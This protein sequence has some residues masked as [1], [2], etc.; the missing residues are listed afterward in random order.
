MKN[1][2]GTYWISLAGQPAIGRVPPSLQIMN[3]VHPSPQQLNQIARHYGVLVEAMHT[4]VAPYMRR[5]RIL[6]DGTF[7][8]MV[9]SYGVDTLQVWPA[10]ASAGTKPFVAYPAYVDLGFA[11]IF[12]R[13]V[14]DLGSFTKPPY[15][16]EPEFEVPRPERAYTAQPAVAFSV[17]YGPLTTLYDEFGYEIVVFRN[18]TYKSCVVSRGDSPPFASPMFTLAGSE[19][20]VQVDNAYFT[21]ATNLP[22]HAPTPSQIETGVE[23]WSASQVGSRLDPRGATQGEPLPSNTWVVIENA[24]LP[25]GVTSGYRV[26]FVPQGASGTAVTLSTELFDAYVAADAAASAIDAANEA[27]YQAAYAQWL[28]DWQQ[29]Y[30]SVYKGWLDDCKA[31]DDMYPSLGPYPGMA[32]QRA[33]ARELQL[34]ALRNWLDGGVQGQPH[35]AARYLEFPWNIA[36]RPKNPL[37]TTGSV[38]VGT[39]RA[40]GLTDRLVEYTVT[41]ADRL[42]TVPRPAAGSPLDAVLF[43]GD[44]PHPLLRD[45]AMPSCLYGWV[46]NGTYQRYAAYAQPPYEPPAVRG[47][48]QLAF[49][50]RPGYDQFLRDGVVRAETAGS[51]ISSDGYVPPGTRITLVHLEYE[52]FDVFSGQWIW[53]PCFDIRLYDSV[54][55]VSLGQY[56]MPPPPTPPANGDWPRKVRV[57][58]VQTL[59]RLADMRWSAPVTVPAAKLK[60]AGVWEKEVAAGTGN[61][62][63]CIVI[64]ERLALSAYPIKGGALGVPQWSGYLADTKA[65]L[66]NAWD[67]ALNTPVLVSHALAIAKKV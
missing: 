6:G 56:T 47:I 57:R 33:A 22:L 42:A 67:G 2:L 18:R 44:Q 58:K 60:D 19:T 53:T 48:D 63:C 11:P 9:S 38:T 35:L 29:W 39:P 27:A 59:E 8:R 28:E 3:G 40:N 61:N 64:V 50:A 55:I 14:I 32:E 49:S 51:R 13:E 46:A 12:D 25:H 21:S 62:P 5:E 52:V 16:K 54:W 1:L 20:Y 43:N 41:A 7:I 45:M 37:P 24:Y 34:T 31:I 4:S 26:G 15:P 23:Y 10:D 36:T 30:D 66:R 17:T 65:I